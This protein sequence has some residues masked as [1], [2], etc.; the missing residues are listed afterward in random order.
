MDYNWSSAGAAGSPLPP[1]NLAVV[2]P[3]V[4]GM[5]DLRWEDP[6]VL[7]R[8]SAHTIVGVNIYR[9]DASDQGPYH[10]INDFPIG[11]QFYRDRTDY[12]RV[13]REPVLWG[14]SWR[15]KG[16][17]PNSRS[18][19]FRV[20]Q[21]IAK[22]YDSAAYQTPTFADSPSDVQFFVNG[23][24]VP[25]ADVFGKGGEVT[26]VNAGGYDVAIEQLEP[27]VIPTAD[28][29]VEISYYTPKNHVGSGLDQ[30]IWYRVTS[31]VLDA[32]TPSGYAESPLEWCEPHSVIEVEALDYIW[33]EAMRRNA[34]ILQQGGERIKFFIRK[35][36]GI[37]CDCCI[38]ER[39]REY[40][41]QPSSRCDVCYGTGWVSGYEGPYCGIVAPDDAER[42]ITQTLSGRHKEH[43]YEVW[44]GPSPLLT[45]RD[46]IVK[47][48][49]ERY[50]VGAVRRPSN[51][52][53]YMQQHFNIRY[54][55]QG[56]IR[57][58]V[59]VDGTTY[60]TWPETRG[61]QCVQPFA[62]QP[63][64]HPMYGPAP[65]PDTTGDGHPMQT[66]KAEIC[67]EN[68]RRGRTR[69]WENQ[70]Y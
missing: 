31:V 41:K 22:R 54:L 6:S 48:T 7:A 53:N 24:E 23:E 18:W 1:K 28:D 67:D 33:R 51:R 49:N 26:L 29:Q 57:Y 70:N 68:E 61:C 42:R 55:D 16:D 50:S 40:S 65:W 14:S 69:V 17:A 38:E 15:F 11:G 63:V 8:N 21:K 58:K 60:M 19:V 34:W 66:E 44:T 27:A 30:V 5:L 9:S 10:R 12:Q 64:D 46:F 52:G 56:D 25:V 62:P 43:T 13:T 47:Q 37:A 3:Y 39:T 45:M 20:Q 32:T 59:P 2:S 35:T 4:I 36:C